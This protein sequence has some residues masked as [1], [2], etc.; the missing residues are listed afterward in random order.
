MRRFAL[1]CALLLAMPG[2]GGA[3]PS[4]IAGAMQGAQWLTSIIDV[5]EGG[6]ARFFARHPH[7]AN[8]AEVDDAIHRAR[9]AAAALNGALTAAEAVEAGDVDKAKGEALAAYAALVK[10]LDGLGVPQAK[11]PAGGAETDEPKPEPFTLPTPEQVGAR[12]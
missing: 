9:Q 10:L 3:W 12:L 6:S 4:I 8:K 5:A 1:V 2:C 11:S 7:R